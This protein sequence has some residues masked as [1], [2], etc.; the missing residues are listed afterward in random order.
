MKTSLYEL[1]LEKALSE[2]FKNKEVYFNIDETAPYSYTYLELLNLVKRYI[3]IFDEIEMKNQKKYVI[4]DNSMDSIAIFIALLYY[5][6]IPVLLNKKDVAG[7]IYDDKDKEFNIN[8]RE[9]IKNYPYDYPE[10]DT[11]MRMILKGKK[12]KEIPTEMNK[13]TT[14]KSFVSL[15]LF[16]KLNLLLPKYF[17]L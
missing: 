4:V 7:D 11:T 9:E 12:I 13:R 3:D 2:E 14:G 16:L 15:F 1:L 6:A 10:P 5:K 17:S 8:Y